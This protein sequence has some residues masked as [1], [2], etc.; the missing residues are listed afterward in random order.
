MLLL[1]PPAKE[2]TNALIQ[3]KERC[4]SCRSRTKWT[5]NCNRG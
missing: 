1:L 3:I 2:T 4:V 5:T